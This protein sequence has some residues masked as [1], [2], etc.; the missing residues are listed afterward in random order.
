MNAAGLDNSKPLASLETTNEGR[1]HLPPSS[2]FHVLPTLLLPLALIDSLPKELS[3]PL[4]QAPVILQPVPHVVA[5]GLPVCH[6]L[7]APH[8]IQ[9]LRYQ[10]P[11]VP[12]NLLSNLEIVV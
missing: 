6:L 4:A 1:I 10:R 8:F 3:L 9:L 7:F 12:D 11:V 5:L 2:F